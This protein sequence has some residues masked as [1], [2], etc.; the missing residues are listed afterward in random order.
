M[1]EIN[2]HT[3][4]IALNGFFVIL[5]SVLFIIEC[6]AQEIGKL[7]GVQDVLAALRAFPSNVEIATNCC[8]ALWS[9]AIDGLFFLFFAHF[10]L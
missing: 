3:L 1:V 2:Y 10:F 7:G 9:L 5:N 8:G 6:A 4:S